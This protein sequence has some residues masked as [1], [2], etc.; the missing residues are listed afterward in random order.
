MTKADALRIIDEQKHTAD[1]RRKV[2]MAWLGGI[3]INMTDEEWTGA[4]ER[5]ARFLS[6]TLE[7]SDGHS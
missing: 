7:L 5:H 4:V 1:I 3:V 6:G 2:L